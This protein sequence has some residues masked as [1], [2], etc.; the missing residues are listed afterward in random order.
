[1]NKNRIKRNRIIRRRISFLTAVVICAVFIAIL[2]STVASAK[3]NTKEERNKYY[4]SIEVKQG[5]TLWSIAEEY[6]TSEYESTD[7][8]IDE[9]IKM[10]GLENDTIHTGSNLV[11]TY[12]SDYVE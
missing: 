9:L 3:E 6:I 11:V 5:D 7:E 2:G 1:M 12:Y 10:N 4:K 8:Y